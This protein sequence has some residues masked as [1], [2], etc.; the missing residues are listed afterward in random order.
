MCYCLFHLLSLLIRC[1]VQ[2]TLQ[3]FSILMI[4]AQR[5]SR[6]SCCRDYGGLIRF[7]G[8]ASTVKCF[9]NNPLVRQ[10]SGQSALC[11]SLRHYICMRKIVSTT[12]DFYKLIHP[13]DMRYASCY[14][15]VI[16]TKGLLRTLQG[17]HTLGASGIVELPASITLS[18]WFA[19]T[20]SR[21]LFLL[22][23]VVPVLF[24]YLLLAF[25]VSRAV[26]VDY[27]SASAR[28]RQV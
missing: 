25:T 23:S 12:T 17:C 9:E 5:S 24:I 22:L 26:K 18:A 10:V 16:W 1:L 8:Q 21:T 28:K 11:I 15:T 7:F 2:C 4:Y 27:R 19:E 14:P 3:Q 13:W 6:A 20:L